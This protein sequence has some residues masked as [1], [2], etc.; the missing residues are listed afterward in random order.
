MGSRG[1]AAP[2]A[3]RARCK[4]LQRGA[5]AFQ[6]FACRFCGSLAVSAW[7]LNASALRLNDSELCLDDSA[8]CLMI[9]NFA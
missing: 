3:L 7:R 9:Q 2:R 1:I 8:I 6:R 4:P 5:G